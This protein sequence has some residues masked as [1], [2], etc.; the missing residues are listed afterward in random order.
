M[1]LSMVAARITVSVLG[2]K[3]GLGTREYEE[4]KIALIMNLEARFDPGSATFGLWPGLSRSLPP[5][6]KGNGLQTIGSLSKS[7]RHYTTA[8]S[9]P[10]NSISLKLSIE[11]SLFQMGHSGIAGWLRNQTKCHKPHY[12]LTF[13]N[14]EA[15]SYL[16]LHAHNVPALFSLDDQHFTMCLCYLFN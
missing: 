15:L 12:C 7:F 10:S 2:K 14:A 16:S 11:A 6:S 1:V 13:V 5:G 4:V 9:P 8:L 3:G